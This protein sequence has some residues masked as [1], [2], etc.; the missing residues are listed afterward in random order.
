MKLSDL[1]LFF[2]NIFLHCGTSV[3]VSISILAVAIAV[4]FL[5]VLLL[6]P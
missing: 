2:F 5:W 3:K 6:A 1:L 4:I